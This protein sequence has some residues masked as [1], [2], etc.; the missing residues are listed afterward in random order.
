M[1]DLSDKMLVPEGS[2]IL[3][4]KC[5]DFDFTN[6]QCDPETLFKLLKF[7]LVKLGGL[8]L[9]APQL[10]IPLRVFVMGDSEDPDNIVGV[11]NPVYT[12]MTP[13]LTTIVEGCLSFPDLYIPRK[14]PKE[15]RV[16][17]TTFD[18]TMDA[19]KFD[20]ITARVFQHEFDHLNGKTFERDANKYHVSKAKKDRK[21]LWRKRKRIAS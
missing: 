21:L 10:G 18:G 7:T 9:A 1:I 19:I 11:F 6:P 4:Q 15:I 17:Y 16:R 14:R 5:D 8:G 20:G 3:R 12:M 2:K 13:E